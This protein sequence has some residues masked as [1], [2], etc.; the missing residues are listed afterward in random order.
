MNE[1]SKIDDQII[2]LDYNVDKITSI[3]GAL[4]ASV[5]TVCTP[6]GPC[7]PD[8][9]DCT[10]LQTSSSQLVIMF[11]D[12]NMRLCNILQRINDINERIEL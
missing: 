10:N 6:E 11:T 9:K 4:S 5:S 2:Q 1:G 3:I 8:K 12:I 7:A